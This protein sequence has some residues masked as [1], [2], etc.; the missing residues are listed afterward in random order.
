MGLDR[1]AGQRS[2][3]YQIEKRCGFGSNIPSSAYSNRLWGY[4]MTSVLAHYYHSHG[5]GIL[6]TL[7]VLPTRH[8]LVPTKANCGPVSQYLSFIFS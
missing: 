2:K 5:T 1:R 3:V 4:A 6:G 7:E 8:K